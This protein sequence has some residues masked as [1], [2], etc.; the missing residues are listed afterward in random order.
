M[1]LPML[2]PRAGTNGFRLLKEK[3]HCINL[4][5]KNKYVDAV[6][7]L[8]TL[9]QADV[10]EVYGRTLAWLADNA[11]YEEFISFRRLVWSSGLYTS[12]VKEREQCDE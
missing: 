8:R 4:C 6:G 3:L 9:D 10:T 2:K 12:Q 11:S 5:R 1:K 7:Y